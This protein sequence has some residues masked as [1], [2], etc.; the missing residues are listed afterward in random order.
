MKT[1]YKYPIRM[2]RGVQEIELPKGSDVVNF[3]IKIDGMFLYAI[4]DPMEEEQ[5][6]RKFVVYG[7]GW[8]INYSNYKYIGAVLL[9]EYEIYHLL[10]IT[11]EGEKR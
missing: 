9:T 2:A 6:I 10:E 3:V 1:I 7:T 4:V 5:E 11:E 8:D